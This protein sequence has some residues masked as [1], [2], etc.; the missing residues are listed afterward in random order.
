MTVTKKKHLEVS[1]VDDPVL[2]RKDYGLRRRDV[3]SIMLAS[4]SL[5]LIE[6]SPR[7]SYETA[8]CLPLIAPA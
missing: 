8:N 5:D 7:V 3:K 2:Q 1:E 6:L 4:V